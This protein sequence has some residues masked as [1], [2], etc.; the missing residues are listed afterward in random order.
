MAARR[1]SRNRLVSV[2]NVHPLDVWGNAREGYDV[3]DVLPSQGNVYIFDDATDEEIVR[4]LKEEGF[5]DKGI[6]TKSVSIDGEVGYDLYI[7]DARNQK[8][9]YELRFVRPVENKKEYKKALEKERAA[10]PLTPFFV[11]PP[12]R[13]TK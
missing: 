3:N 5:I 7:G 4:A 1:Q 2:Y 10:A 13:T 6:R 11:D 8:P 12:R 9:A